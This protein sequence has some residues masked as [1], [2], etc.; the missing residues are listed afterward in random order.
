VDDVFHLKHKNPELVKVYV[1]RV[2]P[3]PTPL[4]LRLLCNMTAEWPQDFHPYS[5][6]EYQ[7]IVADIPTSYATA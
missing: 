4:Q 5:S 1:E 2:N 7:P 6:Q 3:A